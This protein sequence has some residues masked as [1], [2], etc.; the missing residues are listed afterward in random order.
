ME[1]E[2]IVTFCGLCCLDCH[3]YT[4][5][6]P[7]LARD[8]RKELRKVNYAK[9]A[10]T[11]SSLPFANAFLKYEDCYEVLGLMMKFRCKKGCRNGGGP[12][13]CKIRACCRDKNIQ[14]CWECDECMTCEK[15]DFLQANHG[16]GHRKN[17]AAI[18]KK[19]IDEFVKGKRYW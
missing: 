13:S 1:N 2:D 5:K 7:D 11:L 8:L 14:G 12:P 15:L 19:G 6:I 3:G 16:D 18:Q 17:L 4:Q 9:F 10:D